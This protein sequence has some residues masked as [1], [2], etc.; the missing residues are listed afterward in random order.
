MI[1]DKIDVDILF[2][3]GCLRVSVVNGKV[4]DGATENDLRV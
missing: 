2:F 1:T 4:T 3:A